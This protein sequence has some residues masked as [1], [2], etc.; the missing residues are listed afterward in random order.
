MNASDRLRLRLY[1]L[2]WH[3]SLLQNDKKIEKLHVEGSK[4][5]NSLIFRLTRENI[6]D[7][8]YCLKVENKIF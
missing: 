3:L 8:K 5:M 7:L 2:M 4:Y 1:A 6:L